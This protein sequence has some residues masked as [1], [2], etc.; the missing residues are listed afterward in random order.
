MP[1]IVPV[2]KSLFLCDRLVAYRYGKVD[3]IGL[4]NAMRPPNGFPHTREPFCLFAQLIGGQGAVP[5]YID[6][7]FA[8]TDELV[9]TTETR[10]LIF[11]DRSTIVQ[12]AM[13]IEGCQFPE[14]GRYIIDLYCDNHWVADSRL[15]V[16]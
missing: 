13:T 15:L 2:A 7:R 14:P 5:F 3:L 10:Q 4:F 9:R 16:G 11:P 6:I 12:L 1:S 8:R